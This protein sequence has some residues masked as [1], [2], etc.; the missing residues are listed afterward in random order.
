MLDAGY[1]TTKDKKYL[2]LR[3]KAFNWF[4]GDNDT[5]IPLYDSKSKGCGNGLGAE[6]V[7]LNQGAE[8]TISFLLG[9]LTMLE[10]RN[11]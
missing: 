10:S 3:Q 4:L 6:G 5:G 8:S 7:N 9:L 1:K 2:T 11:S